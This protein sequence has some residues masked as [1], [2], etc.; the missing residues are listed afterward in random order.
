MKVFNKKIIFRSFFGSLLILC[1]ALL[2]IS[3]TVKNITSDA[4]KILG[5]DNKTLESKIA[6]SLI[7]GYLDHG[8]INKLKNLAAVEKITLLND[9]CLYMKQYTTGEEFKDGYQLFREKAR[10]PK[11]ETISTDA[12]LNEQINHYKKNISETERSYNDAS[13][14]I[15]EIINEGL[16]ALKTQLKD[17][18]NPN[19]D[20]AR[21][22]IQST[23]LN[24]RN[25][26][27]KYMV[28][29]KEWEESFPAD[30]DE[31]L[32]SRLELFLEITDDIDFEA[33]LKEGYNGK[34]KF[35]NPQYESK[36]AEW[37]KAF[38]AGKEATETAR[39][40]ALTWLIEL[41]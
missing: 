33:E 9:L 40:F 20:M 29:L 10:P 35:V 13:P 26:M 14:E 36:P 23:E 4:L 12:A 5:I 41:N 31:F 7:Y 6:S 16:V 3:F 28:E 19:S 25:S 17:L 30:H 11:P 38:R 21:I 1:T 15:K 37:K 27:D 34:K 39:N 8:N 18:E 32:R 24:N 2:Y 22:I